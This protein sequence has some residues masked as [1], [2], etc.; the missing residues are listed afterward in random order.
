MSEDNQN[1]EAL[2]EV[3]LSYGMVVGKVPEDEEEREKWRRDC[4]ERLE[5]LRDYDY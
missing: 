3:C 5:N 1:L 4:T 2:R